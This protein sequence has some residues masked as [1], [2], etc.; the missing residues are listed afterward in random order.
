ML[1]QKKKKKTKKKKTKKKKKT[2][3]SNLNEKVIV[4]LINYKKKGK[5]VE[6]GTE[7]VE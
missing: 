5:E 6:E 1:N 2:Q 3:V 4:R 7:K